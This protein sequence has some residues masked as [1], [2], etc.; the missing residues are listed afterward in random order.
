MDFLRSYFIIK[1]WQVTYC[2]HII[3]M[4]RNGQLLNFK[5]H[6]LVH[7]QKVQKILSS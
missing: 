5:I 1:I 7:K 6:T 2:A 4:T 3:L